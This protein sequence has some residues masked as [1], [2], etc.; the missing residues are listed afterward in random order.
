VTRLRLLLLIVVVVVVGRLRLCGRALLISTVVELPP[1]VL[2][3]ARPR[4]VY[5][6]AGSRALF[7][8]PFPFPVWLVASSE[9]LESGCPKCTR[10][11]VDGLADVDGPVGV[12]G[13]AD[14]V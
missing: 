3:L 14:D 12:D 1:V 11:D 13:P 4:S 9:S 7:C 8:L 10:R 2:I 6:L 5:A